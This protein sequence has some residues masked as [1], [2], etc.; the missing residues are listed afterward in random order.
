MDFV[1]TAD[2]AAAPFSQR[3]SSPAA[4][5]IVTTTAV[6]KIR[7]IPSDRRLHDR[8]GSILLLKFPLAENL[9]G[10]F[11]GFGADSTVQERVE[12]A[13]PATCGKFPAVA[14]QGIFLSGA[15]IFFD[16]AGKFFDPAGNSG[17][18]QALIG[19]VPS[20]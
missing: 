16:G 3:V 2:V 8:A 13:F 19:F 11:L 18:S 1:A 5:A 7:I 20:I 12:V 10:N 9:A 4:P 15:G 6:S 14:A 17:N